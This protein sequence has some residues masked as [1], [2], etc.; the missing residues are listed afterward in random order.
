M[1]D[2]MQV[3]SAAEGKSLDLVLL[4]LLAMAVAGYVPFS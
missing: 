4:G 3:A 2:E 1:D